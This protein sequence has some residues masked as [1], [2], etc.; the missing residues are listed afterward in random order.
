MAGAIAA[1]NEVEAPIV[2]VD[3]ASGVNATTGEATNAVAAD[4]TV[5]MALP[6]RGHVLH[7]GR[8]LTGELTVVDI[9]IPV[10]VI[11]AN[12]PGV[13]FMRPVQAW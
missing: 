5:T 1:I 7:P 6:K 10:D 3:I 11:A 12:D 9:G 2:A 8:G 13:Y 4:L